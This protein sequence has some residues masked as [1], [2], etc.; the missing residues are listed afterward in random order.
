MATNSETSEEPAVNIEDLLG[1]RVLAWVGGL[2]VLLG[3]A[4]F[5]G[6]AIS[7]GWIDEPTR[8]VLAYL[9]STALFSTG[10]WLYERKGQ[11]QAAL[12]AVASSVA[13]LYLTTTTATQVYD[14]VSAEV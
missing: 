14:L 13:A 1:G 11:T 9:G 10:L 5:L 3:A 4:L 12:A 6:M 7:R 8:V 2:A